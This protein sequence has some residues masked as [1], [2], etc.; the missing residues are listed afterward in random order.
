MARTGGAVGT[1]YGTYGGGGKKSSY[2]A[3]VRL[4]YWENPSVFGY[5]KINLKRIKHD[6][7]DWIDLA[8]NRSK[9]RAVV[10]TVMNLRIP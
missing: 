10:D 1:V 8:Q 5:N 3:L 9:W 4:K 2:K 6:S 7:V